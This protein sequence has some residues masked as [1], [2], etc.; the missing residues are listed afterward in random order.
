VCAPFRLF[1]LAVILWLAH[2]AAIIT[3]NWSGARFIF[4]L[5][6]VCR[7]RITVRMLTAL[8]GLTLSARSAAM[9]LIS[10][11]VA[12]IW[13]SLKLVLAARVVDLFWIGA[14]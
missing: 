11:T 6:P 2:T 3:I 4:E 5:L 12:Q 13:T 10:R 14:L 7:G 1:F 9:R 8:V